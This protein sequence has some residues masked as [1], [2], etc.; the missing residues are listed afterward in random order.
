M[1]ITSHKEIAIIITMAKSWKKLLTTSFSKSPGSPKMDVFSVP[2]ILTACDFGFEQDGEELVP[3]TP[4]TYLPGTLQKSQSSEHLA[5]KPLVINI[6]ILMPY[7]SQ[8]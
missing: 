2:P 8:F 6:E 7:G 3:G 5:Y 1:D 4:P